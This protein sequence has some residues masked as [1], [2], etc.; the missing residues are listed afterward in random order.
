MPK[1]PS[2]PML[3]KH[4]KMLREMGWNHVQLKYDGNKI[5]Y[6]DCRQNGD[7]DDMADRIDTA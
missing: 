4:G 5:P 1:A 6:W 2:L 3:R 7:D